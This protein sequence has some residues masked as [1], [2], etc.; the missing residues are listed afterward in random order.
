MKLAVIGSRDFNDY[1]LLKSELDKI[2]ITLIVSGGAA[3]AEVGD[4]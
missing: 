2:F 1:N 3:G 4:I